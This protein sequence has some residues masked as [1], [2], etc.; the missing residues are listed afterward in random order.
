MGLNIIS[1]GR[2]PGRKLSHG[3]REVRN[4]ARKTEQDSQEEP[5]EEE[6]SN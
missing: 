2:T 6:Q 3:R 1:N 4:R 5:E